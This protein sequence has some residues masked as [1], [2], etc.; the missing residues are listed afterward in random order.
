MLNNSW[1]N[2][3]SFSLFLLGSQD[4]EKTGKKRK[5]LLLLLLLLVVVRQEMLDSFIGRQ[6]K[7][8]LDT[9]SIEQ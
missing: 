6:E 3:L 9:K 4:W 8:F 7:R 1:N 2:N 5:G